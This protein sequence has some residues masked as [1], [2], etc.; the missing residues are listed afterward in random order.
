MPLPSTGTSLPHLAASDFQTDVDVLQQDGDVPKQPAAVSQPS[1]APPEMAADVSRPMA[2]DSVAVST[3]D[4]KQP[5]SGQNRR[6]ET[7]AP[8]MG[9]P[10]R[11]ATHIKARP[12]AS[13]LLLGSRL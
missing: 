6:L 4:L 10:W 1:A 13:L 11:F 9:K 8:D 7:T 3:A 2:K 5:P 12:A